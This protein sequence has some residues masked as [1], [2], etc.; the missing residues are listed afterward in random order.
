[1]HISFG[2]GNTASTAWVELVDFFSEILSHKEIS[3]L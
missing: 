2:N 1:M 3:S